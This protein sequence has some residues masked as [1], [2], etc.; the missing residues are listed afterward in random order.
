MSTIIITGASRGIGRALAHRY[1]APGVNL[2]IC[3]LHREED[4]RETEKL[5]Q[6]KGAFVYAALGDVGDYAF[7]EAFAGEA[8]RLFGP[9]DLLINNAGISWVGLFSEM[10]PEDWDK[11]I[12]TNLT[13]VYNMTSQVLP[14]MIHRKAGQ[15]LNI[16]SVWGEAGA[17]CEV[18]YS[19][20]KGGMNALTRALAKELAPS[21]I[22]V[23]AIACGAIDTEMNHFLTDEEL[24]SLTDEIPAG[25]LGKAEEV[26]ELA[27]RITG[28]NAPGATPYLTGQVITFDGGWI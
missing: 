4:L 9:P 10:R 7:A 17:S 11:V 22:A 20:A 8:Q 14:D 21:G 19:A 16:S 28:Q 13:S 3:C 1:A 6:E 23:N 18:A 25:R 26:A 2:A 15:I 24:L 12:R 5:L 27:Y